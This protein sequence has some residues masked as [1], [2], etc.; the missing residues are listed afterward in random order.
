MQLGDRGAFR[1]AFGNPLLVPVQQLQHERFSGTPFAKRDA[2][3]ITLVAFARDK[4]LILL[5]RHPG[6][7][8]ASSYRGTVTSI[9]IY[10]P[11]LLGLF[12]PVPFAGLMGVSATP[13]LNDYTHNSDNSPLV[14][15]EASFHGP[16]STA[17]IRS[18]SAFVQYS[19]LSNCH[20][21]R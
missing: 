8:C 9:I 12:N 20:S 4:E 5:V 17:T 2:A 3:F 10:T 1:L 14:E 11:N 19:S 13:R 21:S 6:S 7:L 18:R 15:S 16:P